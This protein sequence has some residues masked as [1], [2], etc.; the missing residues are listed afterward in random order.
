VCCAGNRT[1]IRLTELDRGR[2]EAE[3]AALRYFTL[4]RTDHHSHAE[5]D[6]AIVRS[7]RLRNHRGTPG[8]S[9]AAPRSG[10]DYLLCVA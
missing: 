4:S 9:R 10:L 8:A 7:I 2:I 3:F 1:S 6:D 5:Q